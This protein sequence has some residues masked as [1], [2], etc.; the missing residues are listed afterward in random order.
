[1]WVAKGTGDYYWGHY[2]ILL[3]VGRIEA[4]RNNKEWPEGKKAG[5]LNRKWCSWF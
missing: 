2:E 1:M 3:E 4:G 5:V